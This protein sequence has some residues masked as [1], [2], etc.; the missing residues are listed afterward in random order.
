MRLFF[1]FK[2]GKAHHERTF[3]TIGATRGQSK[4]DGYLTSSNSALAATAFAK[5]DM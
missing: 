1:S 2:N 4:Y 5:V 3:G